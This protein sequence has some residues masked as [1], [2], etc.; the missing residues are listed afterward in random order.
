MALVKCKECGHEISKSAKVCPQCG[1]KVVRTSIVTKFFVALLG[2]GLVAAMFNGGGSSSSGSS[3]TTPAKPLTK[4]EVAKQVD[5][6]L[7]AMGMKWSYS[8]DKDEMGRGTI[9]YAIV[10]SMN[11]VN[12]D[13]PYQGEQQATL[14]LRKHPKHGKDVM[15][16]LD[17]GQFICGY[18]GCNV[19]VKFDSGKIQTFHATPPA[20]HDTK[21]LF[22]ESHDRLVSA[23]KKAKTVAIEASFYKQGTRVFEFDVSGLDW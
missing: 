23:M 10:K 22:I 7:R 1:A 21:V 8:E 11:I 17:R 13:F 15:L 6:K 3:A 2:I 19:S 18:D 14:Q 4:E 20:D 16:G 12:F 9:K 5:D